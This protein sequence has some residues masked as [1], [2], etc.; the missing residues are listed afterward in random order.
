MYGLTDE[1]LRIR[2]TAREFVE[3]LMPFEVEAEL[4]GGMLP[5]EVLA[6][7]HSRAIELRIHPRTCCR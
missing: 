5:K 2:D 3:T 4:A 7:H 6:E 1:D